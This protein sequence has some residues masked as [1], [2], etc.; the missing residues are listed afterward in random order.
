MA[1]IK[2]EKRPGSPEP[3]PVVDAKSSSPLPT[4]PPLSS[5]VTKPAASKG[6]ESSPELVVISSDPIHNP[7]DTM[8]ASR[9]E[10]RPR[11]RD[12]DTASKRPRGSSEAKNKWQDDLAE[13]KTTMQRVSD[14]F[15]RSYL[16][17]QL[18]PEHV[19]STVIAFAE[20]MVHN[21]QAEI[22]RLT[23]TVEWLASSAMDLPEESRHHFLET[24]KS[25]K[26]V[27]EAVDT[28]VRS[29]VIR[30]ET[31][32]GQNHSDASRLSRTLSEE[33][34]EDTTDLAW[35][36]TSAQRGDSPDRELPTLRQTPNTARGRADRAQRRNDRRGE[37]VV[38]STISFADIKREE[39]MTPANHDHDNARTHDPGAK[40]RSR[41]PAFPRSDQES[42]YEPSDRR[43][44]DS[45]GR[46]SQPDLP[47]SDSSIPPGSEA[48][49][50]ETGDDIQ[51]HVSC[52]GFTPRRGH[53]LPDISKYLKA[54][55]GTG[56]DVC[57]LCFGIDGKIHYRFPKSKEGL[58][59]HFAE[60]HSHLLP[61]ILSF[62]RKF[63]NMA[64]MDQIF[65]YSAVKI[66]HVRI[67]AELGEQ[68]DF[69]CAIAWFKHHNGKLPRSTPHDRECLLRECV[70]HKT[71]P[72]FSNVACQR[73]LVE[74]VRGWLQYFIPDIQTWKFGEVPTEMRESDWEKTTCMPY[75]ACG[76]D[77][78]SAQYPRAMANHNQMTT[79]GKL[80]KKVLMKRT[81]MVALTFGMISKGQLIEH[82]MGKT[83]L[84]YRCASR[85]CL[86]PS[87]ICY[88]KHELA[89]A[90]K[91]CD[92]DE[93]EQVDF[94]S[95]A[96]HH[97]CRTYA[98]RDANNI[99]LLIGL[100]P[101]RNLAREADATKNS[102]CGHEG[103]SEKYFD[104][105]EL[106]KHWVVK[107]GTG[108]KTL[109]QG[110]QPDVVVDS[111]HDKDE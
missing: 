14:C 13:L 24:A 27:D 54:N 84:C 103:C 42:I 48:S 8:P 79:F 104:R 32:V 11:P 86:R 40:K 26:S 63:G 92:A 21:S 83:Q 17:L 23:Q 41:F 38:S 34:E 39:Q 87:H 93:W 77:G 30:D 98:K 6:S 97:F 43:S 64:N 56:D 91:A 80:D 51:H 59:R 15:R 19:R 99:D 70:E 62:L 16:D 75:E 2:S 18:R 76:V 53:K 105:L 90:I 46:L 28:F 88:G 3:E 60:F 94:C 72:F 35:H 10:K 96:T 82:L 102:K 7:A 45:I 69:G 68:H 67:M 4:F 81:T 49:D 61:S 106:F 44:S 55:H 9:L 101:V 50:S 66:E 95:K 31:S 109:G 33:I 36:S 58:S 74:K 29:L 25:V 111:N 108:G 100:P 1:G 73:T 78:K 107:H 89:T 5:R 20:S 22:A 37:E 65:H 85:T 47:D 71:A 52:C 12:P 110:H 57:L